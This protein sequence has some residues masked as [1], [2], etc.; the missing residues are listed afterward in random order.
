MQIVGKRSKP[1]IFVGLANGIDAK[2]YCQRIYAIGIK[3]CLYFLPFPKCV[4]TQVKCKIK[5]CD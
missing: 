3:Y 4:Q 5:D 1:R 2:T